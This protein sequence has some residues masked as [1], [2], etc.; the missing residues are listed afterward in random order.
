MKRTAKLYK[1][2]FLSYFVFDIFEPPAVP[3]GETPGSWQSN[4]W[5]SR[6]GQGRVLPD[7]KNVTVM[8]APAM[9]PE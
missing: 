7:S 1:K 8:V 3:K 9:L 5:S 6:F 4:L 2:G